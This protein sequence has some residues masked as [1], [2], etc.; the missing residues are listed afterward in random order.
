VVRI[1]L[2]ILPF[3][4]G[5]TVKFN[6]NTINPF[7][8]YIVSNTSKDVLYYRLIDNEKRSFAINLPL[9]VD[10][11]TLCIKGTEIGIV[12]PIIVPLKKRVIPVEMQAE[13]ERSF[14]LNDIVVQHVDSIPHTPAR[15]FTSGER[16]GTIQINDEAFNEMSQPTRLFILLHEL[17]HYYFKTEALADKFALHTFLNMGY[18]YSSALAALTNV[19][20]KQDSGLERILEQSDTLKEFESYE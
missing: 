4:N 1:P 12:L 6:I 17:G 19:L 9:I 18:N 13:V 14:S 3:T 15:I 8:I 16:K 2:N 10:N 11:A 20:S 7:F 5:A